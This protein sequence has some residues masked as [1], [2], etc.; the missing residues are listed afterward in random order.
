MIGLLM[1]GIVSAQE[2]MDIIEIDS[3]YMGEFTNDQTSVTV[4]FDGEIGDVIYITALD[5]QVPV[6]F[7]LYSPGGGQLAQSDD[8]LI[9]NIEFGTAGR[10]TVE[11]IRPE[12]SDAEGEF[13]AFVGYYELAS[14][15]VEDEGETRS[16]VGELADVAALRQVQVDKTAGDLATIQTYG[17]NLSLTIESPDG[18]PIY[19]D[20]VYSDVMVPLFQFPTTGTYI[21]TVQ[22]IEPDGTE[23]ELYIYQ[24]DPISVTA[25][26]PITGQLEEGLPTLFAFESPAGKMW[27]INATLPMNGDSFL[28]VYRFGNREAWETLIEEDYGSGPDGQPR[29]RPFIPAEDGTY[30]L[31]LWYDDWDTEYDEYDFELTVSPSTLLSIPNNSPITGKINN[32]TGNAQYAYSGKTGD[33]IIVTIT[34]L[35]EEGVLSL[36]MYSTEDEVI[37]FT[38]RDASSGRFEVEL[39]LDGVY[40]FMIYNADYDDFSTLEYEIL[41]ELVQ[42]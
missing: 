21:I 5:N 15:G 18:E 28:A 38:G 36:A 32:D 16:Y 6:E 24:R 17:A 39:P 8:S 2:D 25:N 40:Q 31:A 9:R 34:R 4:G 41:V 23:M 37:T 13:T 1:F 30:Y 10:Y 29:I 42:D 14:M 3:T 35:S 7:I 11:F 33:K 12:W 22:T 26:T 27:D 20:G 19:F